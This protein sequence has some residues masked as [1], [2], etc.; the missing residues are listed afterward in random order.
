MFNILTPT[1][2]ATLVFILYNVIVLFKFGVPSS[3]SETYY[4]F[5]KIKK[6]C[7]II[8]TVMMFIIAIC[9]MPGWIAITENITTWSN[10]FVFLPFITAASFAFIGAAPAFKDNE[11]DYKVHIG[12]TCIAAVS[13][14]IWCCAICYHIA[15]IILPL[16]LTILWSIAFIT[17]TYKTSSIYWWEMAAIAS[18]LTTIIIESILL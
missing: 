13:A 12:S 15:W 17:K 8:F 6:G 3:L 2:I 10:N 14:T 16:W 4:L 9:L 11:L 7:G 18:T 1:L 5:N